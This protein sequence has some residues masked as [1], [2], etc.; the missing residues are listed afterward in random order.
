MEHARRR[1]FSVGNPAVIRTAIDEAVAAG[2][3]GICRGAFRFVPSLLS[4][5]PVA[6]RVVFGCAE[7]IDPDL[8]S[9]DFS[10]I[11]PEERSVRAIKC[12]DATRALPIVMDLVEIDLKTAR[13]KRSPSKGMVL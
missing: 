7:V 13:R 1:L 2:L 8:S 11:D 6:I 4:K 9:Y 3:G 10:E 12:E 5:M